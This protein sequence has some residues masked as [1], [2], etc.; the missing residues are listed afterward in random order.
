MRTVELVKRLLQDVL[1]LEEPIEDDNAAL[2]GSIPEFDSMAVVSVIT[3]LEQ[4]FHI[5]IEEDV[6]A[7]MFETIASLAAFVDEMRGA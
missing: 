3:A 6:T 7:E 5:S 4:E 1:N 2:L